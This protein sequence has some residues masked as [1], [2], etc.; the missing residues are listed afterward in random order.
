MQKNAIGGGMPV[1]KLAMILTAVLLL[2]CAS[3]S[4]QTIT[5]S[6]KDAPL[7]Q[8]LVTIKQQSGYLVFYNQDVLTDAKPVS[9]TARNVPL[10]DALDLVLKNQPVSFL[11]RGKMII[12]SRKTPLPATPAPDL[13][14]NPAA[15]PTQ[16]LIGLVRDAAGVPLAG[17]SVMVKGTQKGAATNAKGEFRIEANPDDILSISHIGYETREVRAGNVLFI[18]LQPSSSRLDEV[19]VFAYGTTTRRLSTGNISTIKAEEIARNPVVNVL[20]ALKGRIPGMFVQQQTGQPGTP[21]DVTIRGKST[22]TGNG[23]PLYIVD[24]VPYPSGQLPFSYPSVNSTTPNFVLRGGNALDYLNPAMIESIDVLT[25]ADATAIYGS[26][27]GYGV[28]LITTKKGKAGKPQ[29]NINAQ[30]G[31]SVRGRSP[32]LMT[33]DQYLM[34]RR[35]AFKNDEATPG[36][37]DLDLNGTWPLNRNTDWKKLSAGAFGQTSL[38]NATY[39]GGAGRIN[40]LIGGNYNVQQSIQRSTGAFKSGGLNFNLNSTSPGGKVYFSLSGSYTATLNDML[41]VDYTNATLMAP[42]APNPFLPDG[43]INWEPGANGESF[44]AFKMINKNQSNNL[45]ST[46]EFKY[47]PITGLTIRTVIGFNML[48]GRQNIAYPSAYYDPATNFITK[49]NLNLYNVRT[50]NLDPNINYQFG[51]GSK[52]RLSA[53]AGFTLVDKVSYNQSTDGNGFLSDDVIYNPTFTGADNLQT[54]YTQVPARNLSYFGILNYNWDNKYIINLNGR[55]DGSTKFGPDYR[56]G[57]FGSIG[58]AWIMSS[59]KWFNGLLPVISFAK[60]RGSIGIVGGDA[61]NEYSYL[62]TYSNASAYQGNVAL[63][64]N[65]LANPAL[66]WERMLKREL[67]ANLEFLNG[68]IGLD[69]A[70]YNNR[71][72]NQL[73]GLPLPSTTGSE[74]VNINSSAVI[75]NSGY[76]LSLNTT[77]IKSRNFSWRSNFTISINRNILQSYPASQVLTSNNYVVGKSIQGIKLYDYAGVDPETG[78]YTFYKDG[79]KGQWDLFSPTPLD[80]IKDKTAFVDLSPKYFGSLVNTLSYKGLSASFVFTFTNRMGHN[81]LGS[82][83][84]PAGIFNYNMSETYLQRWQKPGDIT[85]VQRASQRFTAVLLQSNFVSST[86]AYSR[87]LYARLANVNINYNLPASLF[88]KYVSSVSIYASGQ[89]LL[90]ISQYKDLDPENLGV[91]MAPL[92]KFTAGLNITL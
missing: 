76:E 25:D 34:I 15:N 92:S 39:S 88:K 83:T 89:N 36:P 23:Q 82:Q 81:Y 87:A 24:G 35:E 41:S 54:V 49:G 46:A 31:V 17:A 62:N 7:K 59:E 10:N 26:R 30:T 8:V 1:R 75:V 67:A 56:F 73:V 84:Y 79:V 80:Q 21:I 61:I 68:R 78:Y 19:Q 48:S 11:I 60:I 90:T 66:H 70:Y 53:T 91:G 51:L 45:T 86:G 57:K 71:S 13:G 2:V 72:E 20:E 29:L 37:T 18:V 3:S 4:A 58:A 27:G 64:P 33:L 6:V 74:T 85:D 40:Y 69:L 42:N 52:G 63:S 9:V 16:H 14:A 47:M 65:R 32:R 5:L 77:N 55:Y 44:A 28:I 43:N 22:L 50:W 12:L 38:L